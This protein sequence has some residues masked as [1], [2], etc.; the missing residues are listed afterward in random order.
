MNNGGT[1]SRPSGRARLG[2]LFLA[3]TKNY[4]GF[5]EAQE[6]TMIARIWRGTIREADK[7]TYFDYLQKTGL[8]EYA[9]VKNSLRCSQV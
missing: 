5:R 6:K 2:Y 8:K 1:A 9:S 4:T 7:D 3:S